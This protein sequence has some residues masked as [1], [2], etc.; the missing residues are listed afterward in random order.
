MGVQD[1]A[2][3]VERLP[4]LFDPSVLFREMGLLADNGPLGI[5]GNARILAGPSSDSLLIVVGLSMRNR[6]LVFRRDGDEFIAEYRVETTLRQGAPQAVHVERD[7]RVRVA[8]FRETQRSD[9]SIIFQQFVYAPPGSYTLSIAVRDR[10]G[11][12]A[13][14]L[15]TP[16][17]VPSLQAVAVSL[18][19]PIY[20]ATPRTS[21]AQ[22]P[23]L[24]MNPRTTV[25]YGSDTLR[26]Y[27]ETYNL[28]AG[29][30]LTLAA[31]DGLG[32][33]AWQ[34]TIRVDATQ[35]VHGAVIALPPLQLSI[36]RYELRLSQGTQVMAATPFLVA[37]SN[38][39]AAANLQDIVSLLRWFA[40]ADTLRALVNGPAEERAAAWQQFWRATDPNPSTPENEAIEEYLRRI[41]IANERFRDEGT[42]GWLTERGEVFIT[43]GEPNEVVDRRPDMQGRGRYIQWNYYELRLTLTFFD[44]T[45]F[46]RYRLDPRSRAEFQRAANRL[47]R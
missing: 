9:E 8:S 17:T 46:G 26:F 1:P 5:V 42:A 24:V 25:D 40:P 15:E 44:D 28:A 29:S 23:A 11:A 20:Q 21:V 33:V 34:D 32:R 4:E 16:I 2:T 6:G 10:N 18:P 38:Q 27:V 7:E 35:P 47:H 30:S 43:L 3:P 45:G 36:G 12:N 13:A 22:Q 41:Q 37:F 31:V 14:R 39:Y 19:I